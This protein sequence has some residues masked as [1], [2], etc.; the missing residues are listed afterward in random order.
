MII[1]RLFAPIIAQIETISSSQLPFLA[2]VALAIV[3]LIFLLRSIRVV[4]EYMRLVI[5]ALGRYG[6]TRG[7]GIVLV[8]PWE[9]ATR[10]DLRERFLEIPRQTAITKDNA[11]ISI[12]FLVYY[13][14]ID[15]KLSVLQVT[16]VVQ[17][18]LNIATTTLRAVIGDIPLDDVLAK[19]EA[20]NDTLRVKLDEVTERWG[21]KITSV[22]IREIDPPREVQEAMNRQMT[23]ERVRRATVTAASGEREAAIMVAEGQKQAEILKAEGQKQADILRAEGERQAQALRAAGYA[24]ALQ[25]IYKEAKDIDT[26]TMALQYLDALRQIGSSPSTKFVLPLEITGLVQ[27]VLGTM[28]MNN[29]RSAESSDAPESSSEVK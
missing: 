26:K 20:I 3:I 25:V 13:R 21:L 24:M 22:E 5:L 7:P 2:L 14:V 12:D 16:D 28:S 1:D 8:M 6:G 27:Q 23:A 17:A 29:G 10:V 4:P 15:P 18:S 19:R 11:P 9:A